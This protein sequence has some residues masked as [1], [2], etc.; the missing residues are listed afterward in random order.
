[1]DYQLL[2]DGLSSV[3][4]MELRLA[5]SSKVFKVFWQYCNVIDYTVSRVK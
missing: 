3:S 1:M 5:S 4:S 2:I